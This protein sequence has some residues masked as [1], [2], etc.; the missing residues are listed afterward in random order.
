MLKTLKQFKMKT[1]K[2]F[3]HIRQMILPVF[4]IFMMFSACSKDDDYSSGN[5]TP[6]ANE[7]LIQGMSF[8]PST[9]TVAL[10][11]TVKWTNKNGTA[12]TVTSDSNVFD[13]GTMNKDD[14]FSYKFTVA[15][16][17]AYHCS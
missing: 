10:N 17:Y 5:S 15:G 6:A 9:V 12:H 11:S 13:S 16:T 7:V 4:V 3:S 14:Q 2:S 1:I 8:N